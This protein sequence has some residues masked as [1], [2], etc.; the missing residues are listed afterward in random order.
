[1][2]KTTLTPFEQALLDVNLEE[3]EDI[4]AESEINLELSS[5]FQAKADELI[6]RTYRQSNKRPVPLLRKVALVALIA[7][8]LVLTA[9]AVPAVREAI[10]NFFFRDEG[11]HYEF[12]YDPEQAATAPDEIEEVYVPIN[13]PDGFELVVNDISSSGVALMWCN[14]D[15]IWIN[16]IQG[17]IP[18]NP[19]LGDGGGFNSEGAVTEWITLG[20]C[21]VLRIED[22]EWIHYAWT[23]S[24]YEFS[25]SCSDKSMEDE[26][27]EAYYSIQID[28]DMLLIQP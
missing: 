25:L 26:L 22:N 6:R 28:N 13:I 18:D 11:T 10:I 23:S 12:T 21:Q 16:Y 24:E 5:Q 27:K 19:S 8:L 2:K 9:C 14:T 4:P 1:M 3:F 15:D 20:D 17:V 7:S